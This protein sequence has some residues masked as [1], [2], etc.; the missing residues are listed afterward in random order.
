MTPPKQQLLSEISNAAASGFRFY[1][2]TLA[3]SQGV[4]YVGK[5][6]KGRVFQHLA[7]RA[8]DTNLAKR[9]RLMATDSIGHA[10]VA[11]FNDEGE[12]YR[13]EAVL[14]RDTPGLTNIALGDWLEPIERTRTQARDML[15]RI[16]PFENWRP[17]AAAAC[18][19]DAI[20]ASSMRE[21]YDSLTAEL[22]KQIEGPAPTSICFNRA[23]RESSRNYNEDH[24][25]PLRL[26]RRAA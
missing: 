24:G 4:F 25:R 11:Y 23:G 8:Q 16:V 9:S 12:A 13:H 7:R 3:D 17:T 1:V 5:G 21:L 22:T 18:F 2:Y 6:A 15:S 20:G 14:I 26:R 19:M 10:V